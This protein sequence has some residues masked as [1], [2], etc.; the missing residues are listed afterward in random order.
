[1]NDTARELGSAFGI[2][3][4][5][6]AFNSGYRS[7]IDG[8]LRGLSPASRAAAH[9]APAAAISVANKLG[10]SGNGLADAA[11]DAFMVGSRYAMWI[12]AALLIVGAVF[13]FTRGQQQFVVDEDQIVD[14]E[15]DAL[16]GGPLVELQPA[17][18]FAHT[19]DTTA[20]PEE[21]LT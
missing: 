19:A 12:G 17:L 2:A 8:S 21:C 3:I 11:R 1:M 18:A 5:G 9:E 4:L 14:D 7:H 13:V 15:L 10:A 16:A 20:R 6:S